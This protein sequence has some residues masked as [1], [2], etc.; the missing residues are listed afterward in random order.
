[1]VRHIWEVFDSLYNMPWFYNNPT[2][3]YPNEIS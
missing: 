1:L 3:S 2:L